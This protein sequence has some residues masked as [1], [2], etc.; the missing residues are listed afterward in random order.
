MGATNILIYGN[1]QIDM[2]IK[3]CL[4]RQFGLCC[5]TLVFRDLFIDIDLFLSVTRFSTSFH[6]RISFKKSDADL[7]YGDT[8][9][10][11]TGPN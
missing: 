3:V 4:L 9:E 11:V 6:L 8:N 10:R 1:K 2:N 5:V 7:K